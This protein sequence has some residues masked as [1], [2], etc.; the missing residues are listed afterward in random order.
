MLMTQGLVVPV[1][2]CLKA[3]EDQ[4]RECSSRKGRGAHE[5]PP[6]AEE[7]RTV[8]GF[9]GKETQFSLRVWLL[10]GGPYPGGYGHHKLE[11]FPRV[12]VYKGCLGVGRHGLYNKG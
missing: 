3:M 8:C 12:E 10:V 1:A 5:L 2:A 9:L 4:A 11:R 7:L 6:L